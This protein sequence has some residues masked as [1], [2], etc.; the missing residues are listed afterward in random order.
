M[1]LDIALKELFQSVGTRLTER[2]A[3]AAPVEW[4]NIE[5]T[6]TRA[7][8]VDFVCRLADGGIFHLEFQSTNEPA[9]ARRMLDYYVALFKKYGVARTLEMLSSPSSAASLNQRCVLNI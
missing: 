3:G 7:Q 9:M 8:R 2:L 1:N 6:E 4:L 5:L